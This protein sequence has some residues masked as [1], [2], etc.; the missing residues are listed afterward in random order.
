M[1]QTKQNKTKQNKTKTKTEM[2]CNLWKQSG[3]VTMITIS[4]YSRH[5][6]SYK[7]CWNV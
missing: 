2:N 7:R 1:E 3:D 4:E 5:F 6:K